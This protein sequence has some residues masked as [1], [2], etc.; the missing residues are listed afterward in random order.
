MYF[1]RGVA[2]LLGD[3]N[4]HT[5]KSFTQANINEGKHRTDGIWNTLTQVQ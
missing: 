1:I 4:L 3:Q 2:S 5:M